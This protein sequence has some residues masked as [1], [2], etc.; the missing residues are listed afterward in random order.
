MAE[1]DKNSDD[2]IAERAHKRFRRCQDFENDQ[3]QLWLDDMRFV[4]A[5]PE[6]LEQWPLQVRQQRNLDGRPMLT[7]N[8]T[9]Q[10]YLQVVNDG[11]QNKPSCHVHPVSNGATYEAA[12]VF[13]GIVRHIEYISNAQTAYDRASE[14]QVGGGIGYWRLITKYT[15]DNAFDQEIFIKQVNDPLSIYIDPD[16]KEQDGSDAKFGFV[17]TEMPREEFEH[18]YPNEG[19][20][21]SPL[22]FGTDNGWFGKDYVR[23]AEYYEVQT[24]RET[25]YAIPDEEGNYTYKKSSEIDGKI[26]KR[27]LDNDPDV[28]K[29]KID[30]RKVMWYL[31]AGSKVIDSNE[32]AGKYIP[33]VRVIGEEVVLDGRLERKGLVRYMKDAQ[34]MY[35]YNTSSQVEFVALQ[36]KT[37]Y[38]AAVEAIEGFENYWSTANRENH[39]YLP[40]NAVGENGEQVPPPVRQD[41]PSAAPGFMQG[42]EMAAQELMMS[43]GQ[44]ESTFGAQSNEVSGKAIDERQ[45]QGDRATYHFIDGLAKAIRYTGKQL[46]DL[47]PKIYDTPRI[48]RILGEDG[49]EDTVKSDPQA[50]QALQEIRDQQNKVVQRIFNPNVGTYDVVADV[51]PSFDT[52]REE[53]FNATKEILVGN[54]QLVQVIGDLLFKSADFPMAD[55]L[56]ERLKNWIPANI[57]GEGPPP[58]VQQMQQQM[59]QMDQVIQQLQAELRDKQLK[60]QIDMLKAENEQ[61]RAQTDRLNHLGARVDQDARVNIEAYRAESDR[62]K[63]VAPGVDQDQLRAMVQDLMRQMIQTPDIFVGNEQGELDGS[64]AYVA[65]AFAQNQPQQGAPNAGFQGQM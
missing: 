40:Y 38:I 30:K 7:I 31:I 24:T 50:Q 16:I 18:K 45:R 37:P 25:M 28:K 59:Q 58:E 54:P 43:S 32:W 60:E 46:I 6:N 15:D 53:A 13:E 34:R 35:N 49:E 12:Q 65:G 21:A 14:F 55:E 47:I 42:A 62:L 51:G 44:Y 64:S 56:Q 26:E 57:R 48:I 22:G 10:H 4:L 1:K 39:S 19:A 2:S 20:N 36:G 33:I 41:P 9:H 11:K 63:V 5:D 17:Y 27:R 52:K 8:K 61:M 3:R 23:V 29:K